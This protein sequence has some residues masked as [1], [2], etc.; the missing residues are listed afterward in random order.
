MI[1]RA[2]DSQQKPH[3]FLQY[4]LM[5]ASL[6]SHSPSRAHSSH[7]P[8][9]G[10]VSLHPEKTESEAEWLYTRALS[11]IPVASSGICEGQKEQDHRHAI[12][13]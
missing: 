5:M 11:E 3:V 2:V 12:S 7:T 4:A 10:S 9:Y 8:S 6:L 1:G 13:I